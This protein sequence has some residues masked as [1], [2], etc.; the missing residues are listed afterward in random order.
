[1]PETREI[2]IVPGRFLKKILPVLLLLILIFILFSKVII[3]GG[4][5]H[6][7]DF[8]LQFYPWKKYLYENLWSTGSIPFWNPYLL[9][10]VPF[11]TNIQVS[12]FYP[13]GFLYYIISPEIAYV[14][15][16]ILHFCMGGIF[17]FIFM[18]ELETPRTG[19]FLAA[20]IFIFNGFFIGHIYAGHLSFV[21]NY[22]WIPIVFY[23]SHRFINGKSWTNIIAAGVSLGMQI[24]GGSPRLHF[25]QFSLSCSFTSTT[26]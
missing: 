21:Q 13:L 25:T 17:M 9:S 6:G 15:S 4:T 3:S 1:M 11:I 26:G 7:T 14:Y 18:R 16:T 10:G 20:F 19:S 8:F 22:I 24:L 2:K 23:F 5:L 12:I